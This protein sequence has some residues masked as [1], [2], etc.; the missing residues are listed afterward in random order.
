MKKHFSTSTGLSGILITL[1]LTLTVFT[2][3]PAPTVH[4]PQTVFYV[5]GNIEDS[6]GDYSAVYW[7]NGAKV[8]KS[9][10]SRASSFFVSGN[11][12]YIT[13]DSWDEDENLFVTN[14]KNK[15]AAALEDDEY[16]SEAI[17]NLCD[18]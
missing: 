9:I 8:P 16:Y 11:E 15:T 6:S 17:K 1:A 3:C 13:G 5:A 18:I 2:A 7:R 4:I 14:W 12:I 10:N